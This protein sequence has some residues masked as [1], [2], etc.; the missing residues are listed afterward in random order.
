MRVLGFK[1]L[2]ISTQMWMKL[3]TFICEYFIYF[4]KSAEYHENTNLFS[5]SMDTFVSF[6]R[7]YTIHTL[8][9]SIFAPYSAINPK[10]TYTFVVEPHR[11]L[12]QCVSCLCGTLVCMH[13]LGP[14][15]RTL[16][17]MFNPGFT[18]HIC[19]IKGGI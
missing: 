15:R 9:K 5:S 16:N 11:Y 19:Y 17:P 8:P 12:C 13:C 3:P 18:P 7:E 1:C 4:A 10:T 2:R 14:H 6:A